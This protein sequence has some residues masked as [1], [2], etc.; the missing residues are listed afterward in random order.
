MAGP[1]NG[2]ESLEVG[3]GILE[4]GLESLNGIRWPKVD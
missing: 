2:L 3:L 1:G 4:H